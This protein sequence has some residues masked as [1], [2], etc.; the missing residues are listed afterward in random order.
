MDATGAGDLIDELNA[1]ALRSQRELYARLAALSRADLAGLMPHIPRDCTCRPVCPNHPD[2]PCDCV[3]PH[4]AAARHRTWPLCVEG[5]AYLL[6][7][8]DPKRYADPRPPASPSCNTNP[9]TQVSVMAERHRRRENLY[10]PGDWIRL[11]MEAID[12]RLG[13]GTRRLRNGAD[14]AGDLILEAANVE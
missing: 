13:R 3:C 4:L 11:G 2:E 7:I 10:H 5:V 8:S 9:E 1:L 12:A 14:V 6:W